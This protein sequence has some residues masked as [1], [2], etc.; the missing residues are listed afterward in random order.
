MKKK[1]KNMK[2]LRIEA[3]EAI[4]KK[5]AQLV[6]GAMASIHA[7]SKDASIKE[8]FDKSEKYANDAYEMTMKAIEELQKIA[9][10]LIEINKSLK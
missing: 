1:D 10:S 5:S 8:K 4:G 3:M 7:A 2:D 6:A 9:E